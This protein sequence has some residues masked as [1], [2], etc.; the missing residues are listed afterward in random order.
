MLRTIRNG[1]NLAGQTAAFP[2]TELAMLGMP[3]LVVWGAQDIALPAKHAAAAAGAI[4]DCR[5][6]VLEGAGH[7]PM[8]DRP[9]V[10]HELVIEFLASGKLGGEEGGG[11]HFTFS[12]SH[13]P[14]KATS[15][16]P[17]RSAHSRRDR[18]AALRRD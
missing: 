9:E 1:V 12:T 3:V 6:V 11:R 14:A 5:A 10:F 17:D 4:L 2:R 8:I 15:G 16:P 18:S 7:G 13:Q